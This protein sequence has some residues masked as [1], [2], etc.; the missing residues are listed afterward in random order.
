MKHLFIGIIAIAAITF[1][2]C[3]SNDNKS[4]KDSMSEMK[5]DTTKQAST[6]GDKDVK[7]I[8]PTFANVDATAA[9]SIK[10]IV[11]HYLHIKNAL[12]NDNERE[13]ASGAKMLSEGLAKVDKS[14]LTP[15][16]K[17]IYDENEEDLKEH[18][19]HISKSNID[20]QREH[21]SMMS[22]DVYN[23]VKAFGGGRTLYH[24][25]CPM[26]NNNKGA[27][28]ISEMAEIKN[29]YMGSSMP[30]CG[31]VEEKIK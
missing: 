4:G 1:A 10:N 27:M 23:L 18:A 12:A 29:P 31:T 11:D 13:A 20:H 9:S 24:D 14:F 7:E 15:E 6:S 17:K 2:A 3:N 26:A 19:E 21:F 25:H 22:E 16:Q 30:T 5:S 28:W 8:S